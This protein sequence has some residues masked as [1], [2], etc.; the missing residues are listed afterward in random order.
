MAG[1]FKQIDEAF[2]AGSFDHSGPGPL[3]AL[4][5]VFGGPRGDYCGRP[6]PD[7]CFKQGVPYN[8]RRSTNRTMDGARIFRCIKGS[9]P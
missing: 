9:S 5:G 8:G 6:I 3:N 1:T 7:D 2:S 4:A